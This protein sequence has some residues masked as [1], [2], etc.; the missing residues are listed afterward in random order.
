[1]A[2]CGIASIDAL[3]AGSGTAFGTGH[4]DRDAIG[5]VQDLL[6]GQG[7]AGMPA[8]ASPSRGVFGPATT[9]ALRDFQQRCGVPAAPPDDATRA[10][11]DAAT[12][13]ALI[14]TPAAKPTACGGYLSLVLDFPFTGMLRVMSLTTQFEGGG[15][16]AAQNR[17]H[18]RAGL[19]FGLIQWAQR[20]GR[21][22]EILLAFRAANPSR[23]AQIFGGG[24]ADLAQRLIAHTRKPDGG[25]DAAGHATDPAFELIAEPWTTR[26]QQAA[27][28]RDFQ[29]VQVDTAMRAFRGSFAGI[30][31]FAPRVAS[32]RGVAFLLDVANQHGDGG[33]KSIFNA[34]GGA[35]LA[36][37]ALLEAM[38]R[39]SVRRV[40][41]KFGPTSDEADSTRSRRR[42]FRTTPFLSDGPFDPS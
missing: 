16:F 40:E 4:D 22:T 13:R 23:F 37:P 32:E 28:D 12:L 42:A 14:A 6:A 3:N 34:V 11:V 19:S 8:L 20:P 18:D 5:L 41:G 7:A 31:A 9:A 21:L 35:S 33:V 1:M 38:E 39:E 24:D 25:L 2:N 27:L 30:Q 36:E 26:F 17:N 10:T 15:K 29:R